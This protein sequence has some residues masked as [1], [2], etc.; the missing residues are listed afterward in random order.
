MCV[1][2]RGAGG[3]LAYCPASESHPWDAEDAKL[4]EEGP[5][6]PLLL[7]VLYS[8]DTGRTQRKG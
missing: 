7:F 8:S 2:V 1:C 6:S 3:D 4:Y 5:R